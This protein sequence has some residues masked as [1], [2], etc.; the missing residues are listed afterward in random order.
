MHNTEVQDE[1][2][3]N[4]QKRGV[5]VEL[6]TL[7]HIFLLFRQ[8]QKFIFLRGGFINQIIRYILQHRIP[9]RNGGPFVT[10]QPVLLIEI[11]NN[12]C[13]ELNIIPH[14]CPVQGNP[15]GWTYAAAEIAIN[16]GAQLAIPETDI[17]E[18]PANLLDVHIPL[19]RHPAP[20]EPTTLRKGI[21]NGHPEET[22]VLPAHCLHF[23]LRDGRSRTELFSRTKSITGTLA[24]AAAASSSCFF[25]AAAASC[26][27][28]CA[29]SSSSF[30][31]SSFSASKKSCSTSFVFSTLFASSA[32]FA[33]SNFLAYSSSSS[34][35]SS[36][37][38]EL[39]EE[40]SDPEA[41]PS[42]FFFPSSSLPFSSSSSSTS[43]FSFSFSFSS[44]SFSFSSS[45][46]STSSFP[47]SISFDFSSIS[48]SSSSAAA[49]FSFAFFIC[50][51][52]S[53]SSSSCTS[54]LIFTTTSF[55]FSS[56]F[57]TEVT[58]A[59]SLITRGIFGGGSSM[60]FTGVG[61]VCTS[62]TCKSA[63]VPP[64]SFITTVSR[65]LRSLSVHDKSILRSAIISFSINSMKT[66]M[67]FW[68]GVGEGRKLAHSGRYS[69]HLFIF[70]LRSC[71]LLFCLLYLFI[72]IFIV[73]VLH[74]LLN[75]HHNIIL[76]L[77][78][79]R[80][81]SD[82]CLLLDNTRNL[83]WWLLND[84]HGRWHCL[85]F[86]YLQI[87]L[88]TPLEL[89]HHRIQQLEKLIRAR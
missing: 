7:Q 38:L 85:H 52:Q 77:L 9:L 18:I 1:S 15:I 22:I 39:D 8:T 10:P 29:F 68:R 66:S 63:S 5:R 58:P 72:P 24:A 89:Y 35:S 46:F 84:L 51:S 64:S 62:S 67:R 37:S 81:R 36:D 19:E 54:F 33:F 88:S 75:L 60:I 28:C 74:L 69:K 34:S 71:F 11:V 86:E 78:L 55:F 44:S 14:H 17:V 23:G 30:F 12:P 21:R 20:A 45:S 43:S 82:S 13:A 80:N 16:N 42:F 76:L 25:F 40:A 41:D 4:R 73:I 31:S 48:S 49:S 3:E 87:R 57:A 79:L 26:A 70:L 50:S 47:S 2:I 32:C 59:S 56:S 65:S 6:L 83:R 61:I 27:S 53:S